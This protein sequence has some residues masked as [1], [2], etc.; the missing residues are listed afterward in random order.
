MLS[1]IMKSVG[2]RERVFPMGSSQ[3]TI[4]RDVG[5]DLQIPLPE[6]SDMHCRI[7]TEISSG[8]PAKPVLECLNPERGT[9]IN[10]IKVEQATLKHEDIVQIGPVVFQV[11]MADGEA[12]RCWEIHRQEPESEAH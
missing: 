1:L 4:G 11:S 3:M 5:C 9:L 7:R 10:G 6:I 2:Q 8:N 12:G